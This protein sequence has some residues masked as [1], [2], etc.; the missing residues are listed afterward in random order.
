MEAIWL[1][2]DG[3]HA[4]VLIE[5]TKGQWVELIRENLDGPFSHIIEPTGIKRLTQPE[6][7]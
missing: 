6:P 7:K 2:R 1:R 3:Q 5:A 4:V